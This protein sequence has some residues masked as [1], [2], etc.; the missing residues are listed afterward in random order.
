MGKRMTRRNQL[1]AGFFIIAVIALIFF[2]RPAKAAMYNASLPLIAQNAD[3]TGGW[4]TVELANERDVHCYKVTVPVS[5]VIEFGIQGT[6]LERS[7]MDCTVRTCPTATFLIIAA[8]HLKNI[9]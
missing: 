8:K 3:Y 4:K 6:S 1:L 9:R 7:E 2:A 5:G